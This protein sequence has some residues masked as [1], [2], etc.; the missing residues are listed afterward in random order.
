MMITLTLSTLTGVVI[1]IGQVKAAD[2]YLGLILHKWDVLHTA[3]SLIFLLLFWFHWILN[4]K[5]F[6]GMMKRIRE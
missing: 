1:W 3:V 5:T 4:K 6:H 2:V